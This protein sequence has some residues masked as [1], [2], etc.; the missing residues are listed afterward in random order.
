ML[1]HIESWQVIR[2]AIKAQIS[3]VS[4]ADRPSSHPIPKA[5]LT[6]A[7]EPPLRCIPT[8]MDK[9]H[10]EHFYR[11]HNTQKLS[12]ISKLHVIVGRWCSGAAQS[13]RR[14][15]KHFNDQL[16]CLTGL[17]FQD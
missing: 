8:I 16:P 3:R 4:D 17:A 7:L 13:V 12:L 11:R 10:S 1:M 6:V 14:A 2:R 5:R 9:E 15:L